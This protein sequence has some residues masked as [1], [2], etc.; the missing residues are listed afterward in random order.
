MLSEEFKIVVR[1]YSPVVLIF[2]LVPVISY[3]IWLLYPVRQLEVLVIDKSVANDKY[4][5]H[6]AFFWLLEYQKFQNRDGKFYDLTTDYY[7]F[8]LGSNEKTGH[9]DDFSDLTDED[10]SDVISPIDV[11]FLA[12]TYGILNEIIPQ[13]E[14]NE[15]SSK[16]Y[17]GVNQ[18][19]IS[20]IRETAKQNKTVIVEFGA[21]ESPTT[22]FNRAELENELGIKWTGWIARYFN[23]LDTIRNE[24]VPRWLTKAYLEQHDNKWIAA[25]P[26]VVFV[27]EDGQVEAL[28]FGSD[29]LSRIPEIQTQY[30]NKAD[31][32]LP[33]VVP[34]PDWF[35]I[36]LVDREYEVISYFDI[37]P[38]SEGIIK[39]KEMGLPRYFPAAVV[40]NSDQ[41]QFYYLAGDFT[42]LSADLGSPRYTGLPS[43]WRSFHMVSNYKDREGFY[44][45]YYFPLMSQILKKA[46]ER[47]TDR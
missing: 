23:E 2:V 13:N 6:Q 17:G 36:V 1:R 11:I 24:A 20:L 4:N 16:V 10:I 27:H 41:G 37:A 15:H 21:F 35:D 30:F 28:T 42:D 39:L 32:R 40:K 34:Y 29:Y 8:H 22:K 43:L 5:E 19:E 3:L 12:D 9:G 18:S 44:W 31:F 45:N 25:G 38:T 7:G 14:L 33:E 26:G 47:I 46:E